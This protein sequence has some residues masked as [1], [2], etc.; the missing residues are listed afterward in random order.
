MAIEYCTLQDVKNALDLRG[1]SDDAWIQTLITQ[2]RSAIDTYIGYNF[3]VFTGMKL[4][5]GKDSA[6][7]MTGYIQSID[8]VEEVVWN[9]AYG[10]FSS[11]GVF[12]I[13]S[14]CFIGPDDT[15][16]GFYISRYSELPFYRGNKNYRVTGTFGLPEVPF[17]IQRAATRL[18][19]HYFKMRDVSYADTVSE[20][21]SIRQKYSKNM[22]EDV[23]E[24]LELRRRRSF[25]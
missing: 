25:Y 16:P 1:T 13:T 14:E 5:S 3:Q 8:K 10:N 12:D 11:S 4:F 7:L 6:L 21:G 20:Q 15:D 17:E 19:V 22:P 9:P 24:L 2:A 18:A 23:I